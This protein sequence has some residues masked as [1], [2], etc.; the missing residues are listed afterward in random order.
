MKKEKNLYPDPDLP[1]VKEDFREDIQWKVFRVMAELVEGFHFLGGLKKT[2]TI[3]G[4][5]RMSSDNPYYKEA[6]Q[7]G[8]L[9]AENKFTVITGGGPGIMKAANK[10]AYKKN[11]ESVGINIQLPSGQRINKYVTK[12]IGFHYFF[13]RK[14]MLAFSSK[15]YVF[16]PGGFGTLDEF[17]EMV[18]LVQ[19]KKLDHPV[20]I[21]VIGKDYW[22]PLF[23]W[24]KKELLIKQKAINE[25][26]LDIFQLVDSAEE[27]Y[28]IIKKIK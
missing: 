13:T 11:G 19:T 3:F 28:D 21:I 26:N 5:S 14:L 20:P 22:T 27:A 2:I 17:F 6:E 7:L 18:T 8:E 9:L 12:G 24:V 16:F 23:E 15:A 25:E 10:G 4:S 1:P